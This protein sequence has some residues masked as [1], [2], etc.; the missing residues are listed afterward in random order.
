MPFSLL[1]SLE[2]RSGR[3]RRYRELKLIQGGK[4]VKVVW[5]Y[6]S[7]REPIDREHL[8]PTRDPRVDQS[9][10]QADKALSHAEQ[11]GELILAHFLFSTPIRKPHAIPPDPVP[12]RINCK[13]QYYMARYNGRA[14]AEYNDLSLPV[15]FMDPDNRLRALRRK[16]GLTQLE[17]AE[18][19][20]VSQPAISQLENGTRTL[21]LPWM[22][23]FARALGCAPADLLDE[24][25]NPYLLDDHER[26]LVERY[27]AADTEQREMLE[28]VA[29]AVVPLIANDDRDS[30]AG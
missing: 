5:S 22:R 6:R 10:D 29:A 2:Q 8:I 11:I 24:Q 26:G 9:L 14:A 3:G 17:L 27:R 18:R 7:L 13:L 30:A 23:T 15:L 28:R 4:V 20:G 25:D 19:T 12:R 21:D 1:R 16:A